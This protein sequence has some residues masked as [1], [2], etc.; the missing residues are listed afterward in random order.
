MIGIHDL[1]KSL[2]DRTR[3]DPDGVRLGDQARDTSRDKARRPFNLRM[4]PRSRWTQLNRL[5]T[6]KGGHMARTD[7]DTWEMA[8]EL[9]QFRGGPARS[10]LLIGGES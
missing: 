4:D 2:P 6:V 3:P 8:T 10:R 5:T 9:S 1:L 7:N